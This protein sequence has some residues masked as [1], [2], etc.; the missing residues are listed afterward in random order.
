MARRHALPRR[1]G[2]ISPQHRTPDVSTWWVGIIASVWFVLVSLVSENALF[3]SITA[4]SL[5]IAVYYALTGIAGAVYY[6]RQ[7]TRSVKSFLRI[8]VGPVVGALLLIW[9]LVLSIRDIS[10]PENSY[11]EQAWLGVGPPLVIG[12]GIFLVGL[13]VMF[14]WRSR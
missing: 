12:V 4:L 3:D 14:W 5:L 11:T 7:L 9:L 1:L 13:L 10:D 6:R 8:G 2:H